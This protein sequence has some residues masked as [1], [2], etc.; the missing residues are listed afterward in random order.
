MICSRFRG[1]IFFAR[2]AVWM[3]VLGAPLT[4]NA[5]PPGVEVTDENRISLGFEM[6]V[7]G[8]YTSAEEVAG[9]G[10]RATLGTKEWHWKCGQN[11]IAIASFARESDK[12]GVSQILAARAV[13]QLDAAQNLADEVDYAFLAGL[14]EMR[15]HIAERLLGTSE[16]ARIFRQQ[17]QELRAQQTP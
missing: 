16:E 3:L 1:A 8:D 10:T 2:V 15:A 13:L 4:G 11:L 17:A 9:S 12:I 6:A 14:A 7:A 5:L